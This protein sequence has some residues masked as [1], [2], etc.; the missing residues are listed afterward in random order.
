M[1]RFAPDCDNCAALCC[2]LLPF[3]KGEMFAASKAAGRP[4]KHLGTCNRCAIHADLKERGYPGCAQ[5]DCL[6]AGQVVT[7]AFGTRSWQDGP[8]VTE[9]MT[10]AFRWVRDVQ[11][12]A[13]MLR[14]CRDLAQD[15]D[16]AR[17]ID[18][19]LADLNAALDDLATPGAAARARNRI[20]AADALLR[21]LPDKSPD[22]ARRIKDLI[23]ARQ[24]HT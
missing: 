9:A 3:D 19:H 12:R 2:V 1:D 16:L 4:C 5:F 17:K 13:Q 14:L 21:T 6:G 18:R 10:Q 7:R 11:D 20:A 22:L 23:A 15:A 8:G 24:S